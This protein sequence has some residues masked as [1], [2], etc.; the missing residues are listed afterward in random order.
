MINEQLA[1]LKISNEDP[2]EKIE[3]VK[4]IGEGANGVVWLCLDKHTGE[5]YAAKIADLSEMDYLKNEIAIHATTLHENIVKYIQ[6]YAYNNE[7]WIVLEY[8]AGGSL[9]GKSPVLPR[10]ELLLCLL[11]M[12]RYWDV[13]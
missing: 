8:M 1:A 2:N 4:R 9:T 6:S 5:R 10:N 13:L 3:Q 12:Q 7:L 11:C